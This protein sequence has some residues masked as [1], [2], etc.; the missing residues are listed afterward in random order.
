M[1]SLEGVEC[2][3]IWI[4]VSLIV[5]SSG[6]DG[7][8]AAKWDFGS[9]DACTDSRYWSNPQPVNDWTIGLNHSLQK[10]PNE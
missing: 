4:L 5:K 6:A 3:R 2:S 7:L 8:F 10:C 1:H 9:V